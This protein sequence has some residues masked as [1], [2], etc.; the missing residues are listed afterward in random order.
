MLPSKISFEAIGHRFVVP[1]QSADPTLPSS[2]SVY[3]GL[4]QLK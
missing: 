3:R 4:F 1:A 2:G